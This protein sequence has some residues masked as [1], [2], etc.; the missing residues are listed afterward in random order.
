MHSVPNQVNLF[1]DIFDGRNKLLC[2][3]LRFND[4]DIVAT[5][6]DDINDGSQYLICLL[7][8]SDAADE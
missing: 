6:L 1:N 7:Y 3:T 2:A 5:R 8:T 4:I